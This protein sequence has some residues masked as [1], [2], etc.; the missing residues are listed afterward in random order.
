MVSQ[1][2]EGVSKQKFAY[3]IKIGENPGHT[4]IGKK[5]DEAHDAI[6]YILEEHGHMSDI[7]DRT[8]PMAI[9]LFVQ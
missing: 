7:Y 3:L 4:E 1:E 8:Y 5:F 2:W 9:Q 6:N